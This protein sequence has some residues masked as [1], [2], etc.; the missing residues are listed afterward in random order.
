MVSEQNV[1]IEKLTKFPQNKP[2]H[3][4]IDMQSSLSN[5][6]LANMYRSG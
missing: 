6:R 4:S 3:S 2:C 1:A 5:K